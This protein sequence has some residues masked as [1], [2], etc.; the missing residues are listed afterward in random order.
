ML[1]TPS[2]AR[3]LLLEKNSFRVLEYRPFIL[4]DCSS[5]ILLEYS[6][7]RPCPNDSVL[8]ENSPSFL[9]ECGPSVL[10]EYGPS[11]LLEDRLSVG[12]SRTTPSSSSTD[13]LVAY[14]ASTRNPRPRQFALKVIRH[15]RDGI[16]AQ[17]SLAFQDGTFLSCPHP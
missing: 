17:F 7:C 9:L 16:L 1:H 5:S 12:R 11:V 6:A 4:L 2:D 14:P 13:P 10:L 15:Q 8:L 3:R